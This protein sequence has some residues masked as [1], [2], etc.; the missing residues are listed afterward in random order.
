[1]DAQSQFNTHKGSA[2]AKWPSEIRKTM[3]Q[4]AWDQDEDNQ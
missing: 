4:E 3:H 1:M 2:M